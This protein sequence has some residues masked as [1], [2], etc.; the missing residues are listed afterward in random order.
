MWRGGEKF[1]LGRYFPKKGALPPWT[2]KHKISRNREIFRMASMKKARCFFFSALCSPSIQ[3][4]KIFFYFFVRKIDLHSRNEKKRTSCLISHALVLF[5]GL[6]IYGSPFLLFASK[7]PA[8]P[9]KHWGFSVDI[10]F[11]ALA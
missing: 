2:L 9:H 11:V 1:L 8:N 3:T 10:Y 4:G 7:K 6:D 5:W